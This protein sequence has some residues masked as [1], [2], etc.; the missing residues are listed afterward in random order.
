MT[1]LRRKLSVAQHLI[2][3]KG[4]DTGRKWGEEYFLPIAVDEMN[5]NMSMHPVWQKRNKDGKDNYAFKPFSINVIELK[6]NRN[7]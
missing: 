7:K 1:F 4:P 2:W 5:G 3:Y 6:I